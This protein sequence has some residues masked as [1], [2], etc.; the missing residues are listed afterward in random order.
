[1][2]T[3]SGIYWLA[4]YPK[5]GNTWMRA[6]IANLQRGQDGEVDINALETGGIASSRSWLDELL[7]FDSADL[8]P[9]EIEALRPAVYR[10]TVEKENTAL[11][12]HKIHDAYLRLANGEPLVNREATRGALYILRNPLDVAISA[13]H[14]WGCSIDGAIERMGKTDFAL[15]KNQHGLQSQVTQ[16]LLSWSQH[17]RSW[18]DA[19]N[20][21]CCV[22]RYE[23]MLADGLASFTRASQF[24]ELPAEPARIQQA[25][26]HSSFE[27]LATQEQEK[28]F[29]ERSAKAERFF[30]SGTAGGWRDV[31]STAQIDRVLRDH[32]AVMLRFAY[33]DANGSPFSV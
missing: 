17:V 28:G 21:A 16:R 4:S 32:G 27:K 30:R 22:L 26:A 14:H 18:V 12:Y 23:D 7:G 19:E 1:M 31:L 13:S 9:S 15:S 3:A 20:L 29:R 11:A 25:M 5:S 6:F 24:L 2:S 10:W 33:L 8:S